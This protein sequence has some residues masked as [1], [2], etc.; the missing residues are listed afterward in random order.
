MGAEGWVRTQNRF[1]QVLSHSIWIRHCA[2]TIML[3]ILEVCVLV[4][5]VFCR[6]TGQTRG[7]YPEEKAGRS[8]GFDSVQPRGC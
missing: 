2:H 6:A 5:V 1:L 3:V 4:H 7:P 8:A